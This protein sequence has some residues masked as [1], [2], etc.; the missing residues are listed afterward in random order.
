[1]AGSRRGRIILQPRDRHLLRE[2]EV[3]RLV[4][5]EQ[6]KLFASFT[7]TSRVNARLK[8][9]TEAGY[10]SRSFV[11]TLAGSRKAI[12]RLPGRRT[13]APRGRARAEEAVAHQLRLN[14]VYYHLTRTTP[15]G[16]ADVSCLAWQRLEKPICSTIPLIPDG[17]VELSSPAGVLAAFIEV[18]LGSEALRIWD[19]KIEHYIQLALSG[20]FE[21]IFGH[22]QFRVLVVTTG[23]RRLTHIRQRIAERTRSVFWLT[24][25]ADLEAQ[26][27]WSTIW[28]RPD[29]SPPRP[30]VAP[31]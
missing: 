1:M 25:F 3:L 8:A 26:G 20:E 27:T 10:L 6:A 28:Q 23:Q 4:D 12:Y 21:R 13:T 29:D 30:L 7:S 22:R 2:L 11:G 24:T 5:R 9:L 14:E 16:R 31:E 19:G 17:Y 15:E 18:D